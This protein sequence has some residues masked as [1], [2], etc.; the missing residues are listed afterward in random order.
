MLQE[1]YENVFGMLQECFTNVK[2]PRI[3]SYN[4]QIT[5]AVILTLLLS[6]YKA[7]KL[8]ATYFKKLGA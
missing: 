6:A 4:M 2:I 8:K 1:C 7:N 5:T 3:L